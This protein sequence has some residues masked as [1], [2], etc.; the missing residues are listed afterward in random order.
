V[1]LSHLVGLGLLALI[2]LMPYGTPLLLSAGATVVLVIV[3]AWEWI[4]LRQAR[5]SAA[6]SS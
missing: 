6:A 1:S 4:S 3:A 2:A 5:A